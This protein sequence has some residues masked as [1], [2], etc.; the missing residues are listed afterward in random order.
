MDKRLRWFDEGAA[1]L[2]RVVDKAGH[3]DDLPASA[4]CYAC[5]CCLGLYDREAVASRI[6][7]L[8]DVPPKALGGRP[9]LL[10]CKACNNEAGSKLDA[11]AAMQAVGDSMARGVDAGQWVK[12]IS[13]ADGL[14][15][16]GRARMTDAGLLFEGVPRQNPPA[17]CAA[18]DAA[19]AAH[20]VGNGASDL[21][22]TVHTGFED[23]RARLSL[24]RAAYLAAFAGLGWTYILQPALRPVREQLRS[25]EQQILKPYLFRDPNAPRSQ[26]GM[27]IVYDPPELAA[28]AVT[29][30]EFT[31]FLPGLSQDDDWERVAASFARHTGPDDRLEISLHGKAV[32]WPTSPTFFLDQ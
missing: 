29:I 10:T 25:P 14:P 13:Y 27:M 18:F 26:R 23:G 1:A 15:L 6:L 30:G 3:G 4:D 21:S 7:T 28:V 8:E 32:A 5:P 19:L 20:R 16:R 17:A 24:I 31:V 11:D 22:I 12:A 2:R 9:M